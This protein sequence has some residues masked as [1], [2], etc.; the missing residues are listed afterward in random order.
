MAEQL[1]R[2]KAAKGSV[3]IKNSRGW[4]Q[5]VFTFNG[6][7]RYLSLGVTDTKTSRA[8]AQMKAKQ[9]ELDIVS[10]NF[11]E[12][13]AKYKPQ[14]A[15]S[16]DADEQGNE[17]KSAGPDLSELWEKFVEYKRPQCSANTM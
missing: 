1:K 17:K 14:A 7:R 5:L 15:V 6:R 11:D 8:L 4:L 16:D 9:I 13:L 12:T 10:G 2:R 3:R